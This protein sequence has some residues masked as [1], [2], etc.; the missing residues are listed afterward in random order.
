MTTTQSTIQPIAAFTW[1]DP[2]EV[3]LPGELGEVIPFP[4]GWEPDPSGPAACALCGQDGADAES[5]L[6][7][8]CVARVPSLGG[9]GLGLR[10]VAGLT[11]DT[12][13]APALAHLAGCPDC[14]HSFNWLAEI[15]RAAEME[16]GGP[17]SLELVKAA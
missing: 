16:A 6:C 8:T 2:F 1:I 12:D 17:V 10:L 3:D 7:R 11:G 14:R 5:A 4:G 13:G 15:A 9:C